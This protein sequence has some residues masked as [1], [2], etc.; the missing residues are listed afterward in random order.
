MPVIWKKVFFMKEVLYK[1]QAVIIMTSS[2]QWSIASAMNSYPLPFYCNK[3][4]FII[5]LWWKMGQFVPAKRGNKKVSSTVFFKLAILRREKHCTEALCVKVVCHTIIWRK[6]YY[7]V[8]YCQENILLHW[9]RFKILCSF[10]LDISYCAFL[11][12]EHVICTRKTHLI[13]HLK[14]RNILA[15][16]YD[17][18]SERFYDHTC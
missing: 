13:Y 11:F 14:T 3:K 7:S 5:W 8:I 2:Y 17:W 4:M 12:E 6:Y 1:T 16:P 10:T 15:I 18:V 9:G